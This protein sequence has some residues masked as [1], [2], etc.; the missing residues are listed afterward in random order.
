[1]DWVDS[2]YLVAVSL[3]GAVARALKRGLP[4]DWRL[5]LEASPCEDLAQGWIWVHAV[6]V[7]ELLL[8]EG[9]LG[10]LRDAGH[11][12]HVTTGTANGL[13][14]LERR[15]PGWDRGTGRV[16]GGA[17]PLDDPRGLAPF[18]RVP[19]GAFVCLETEIWPNL[20]RELEARG[21]PRCIVNGRLTPRSLARGGRWLGRAASRLTLVAARDAA[22][23][24]A[25]RTLGAPR[26][27]LGGNLKADL[28]EPRPLHAG[29]TLLREAWAAD[30]V[31]VAGNTVEGEEAALLDL[32]TGL[33][34][35][36]PG[37]RLILAPRQPRRFQEV[38]GL[39][40]GQPF[41]RASEPWPGDARAWA[42]TGILLA[43][44]LGEL[45]SAYREGTLALV[46]GGWGWHGGHNPLEPVRF[47][48]P[49]LIGP[50]F[51]NFED[52]VVPLREAGLVEVL[53]LDG[54]AGRIGALLAATPLRPALAGK[55]V[56]YPEAL[57]GT[58]GK[59]AALLKN[60]LPPAR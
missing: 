8:A 48:L 52:L 1:M 11:R 45:A 9:L 10:I 6:S 32:W 16:T 12:L 51:A 41:R 24:E 30:P 14:L 58:L 17:F 49:T 57:T 36:W 56:P 46:G 39:L 33:R 35:A 22:S 47:G 59:T 50:G 60:C 38:A 13:A 2:S 42:D 15:L 34:A 55:P 26:V 40:A 4:P 44:T 25:W 7:G 21:I 27:D 3:A 28:P 37:L 18:L 23:A 53:P 19:P 43:D 54:L 31:L 29:W 5:R 20:L